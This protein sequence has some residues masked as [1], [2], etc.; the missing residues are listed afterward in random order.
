MYP[1]HI[2]LVIGISLSLSFCSS[3]EILEPRNE[4][5][6]LVDAEGTTFK[7]A[8]DVRKEVDH[9]LIAI[10]DQVTVV[11]EAPDFD[12]PWHGIKGVSTDD[13]HRHTEALVYNAFGETS[14]NQLE[15]DPKKSQGL[16]RDVLS[17]CPSPLFS[18]NRRKCTLTFSPYGTSFVSIFPKSR[19]TV[20]I[21]S[22]RKFNPTFLV[23]LASG[24][25]LF[26]LAHQL[27]K[28]KIFQV[29]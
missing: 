7:I 18:T 28:S 25:L 9:F 22:E 24:I 23:V 26:L 2:F 16:V 11:V 8:P 1:Q 27:S 13:L 5:T 10:F 14:A 17:S 20:S 19:V 4:K 6:V 3:F 21:F 12:F 29:R 15:F